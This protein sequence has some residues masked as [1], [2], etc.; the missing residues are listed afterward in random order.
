MSLSAI[1]AP[2][3]PAIVPTEHMIWLSTSITNFIEGRYSSGN[4]F[5][6]L[7]IVNNQSATTKLLSNIPRAAATL[8]GSGLIMMSW[9][10][11][12]VIPQFQVWPWILKRAVMKR[13]NS[14]TVKFRQKTN[15]PIEL[16]FSRQRLLAGVQR[17][18]YRLM[19]LTW[20]MRSDSLKTTLKSF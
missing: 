4:S 5:V 8:S 16:L 15:R 3:V 12:S 20:Q 18:Y 17:T 2:A 7:L 11:S 6:Y 9:S 19:I 10:V 13:Q 1:F 14:L